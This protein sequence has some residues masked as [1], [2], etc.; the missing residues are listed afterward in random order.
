[1]SAELSTGFEMELASDDPA[2]GLCGCPVGLC[3]RL[4]W[5]SP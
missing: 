4:P 3:P 1:M 2:P 5:R